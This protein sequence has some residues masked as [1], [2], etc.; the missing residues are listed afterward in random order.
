MDDEELQHD[1]RLMA[2][3]IAA[4][5]VDEFASG[6]EEWIARTALRVADAIIVEVETTPLGKA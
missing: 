2:A 6:G 5:M 4:G 1:R 3:T